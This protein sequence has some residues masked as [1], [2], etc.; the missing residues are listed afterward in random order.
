MMLQIFAC[1]SMKRNFLKVKLEFFA[2]KVEV[3]HCST[4]NNTQQFDCS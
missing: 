2:K 1:D 4:K 3:T